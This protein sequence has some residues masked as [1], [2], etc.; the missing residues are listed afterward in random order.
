MRSD[1]R[2]AVVFGASGFIGGWV[3]RELQRR[4][5]PVTA[6]VRDLDRAAMT[7]ATWPQTPAYERADLEAPGDGANVIR[8]HRP[9]VT[10]QCRPHPSIAQ[11]IALQFIQPKSLAR[12][13]NSR[14]RTVRVSMPKTPMDKNDF[15]S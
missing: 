5:V 1:A 7:F 14:Q 6:V 4:G 15:T 9:S 12:L 13:G 8:R 2:G 3:A 11:T 10:A